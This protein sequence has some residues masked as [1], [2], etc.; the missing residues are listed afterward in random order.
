[1]NARVLVTSRSFGTGG[2]DLARELVDAGYD[3][4][5][6]APAHTLDDLAAVLPDVDGW[7]AGTGPI[8]EAHL[9]LAPRLR[10][11][12]RYGVG[13]EK[14]D[15]TSAAARGITVTNTPGANSPAVAEHTVALLMAALRGIPAADRRVRR[16]DWSAWMARELSALTIGVVGLG[17][18][19][20]LVI[21]RLSGFG[22]R[23]LG[24]DPW[25]APSDPLFEVITPTDVP[26]LAREAD[27]L[28]LHAPGGQTVIDTDWLAASDRPVLIVN[29]A[30][31]DLVDE[32]ALADAIRRGRVSAYAAD[33]LATENHG[34]GN[35]DG[36]SP[37]LAPDLID[38]VI[39]TP[40]LAAQTREG[41]DGMGGLATENLRA[42]LEG[43]R[44]PYPVAS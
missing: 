13:F 14:V 16:G 12:S 30:R 37:L 40:H 44:P 5:R 15:V 4:V 38:Q 26:T 25:V 42:V 39:I 31:A 27:V 32:T 23:V 33:T 3:I 11:I 21:D 28:T 34:S 1:M 19:G 29:T 2:R 18:I 41:V 22:P 17:R 43:R 35:D 9:E 6:A 36:A 10:V 8:T 24:V 20:R 7:I